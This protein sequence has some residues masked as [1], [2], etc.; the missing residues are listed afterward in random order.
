MP[1]TG[2][3]T[4]EAQPDEEHAFEPTTEMVAEWRL[5]R[6]GGAEGW[7][8]V[9]RTRAEERRWGLEVAMIGDFGLTLPPVTEPLNESR[10]DDQLVWRMG[11]LKQTRG[12]RVRAERLR[13]VMTL[14]LWRK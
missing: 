5:L 13:R 6:T 4:L 7:S 3:V 12:R 11:T 9:E 2:V 10:R 14:G 8:R 1:D